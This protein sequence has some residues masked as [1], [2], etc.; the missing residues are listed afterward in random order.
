MPQA[1]IGVLTE[2]QAPEKMTRLERKG[3]KFELFYDT[4]GSTNVLSQV[5]MGV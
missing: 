3:M 2:S 1:H 4:V 5:V